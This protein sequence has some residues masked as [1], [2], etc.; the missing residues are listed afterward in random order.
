[1][2]KLIL[3]VLVTHTLL[4]TSNQDNQDRLLYTFWVHIITTYSV[5]QSSMRQSNC[6][7]MWLLHITS[8]LNWVWLAPL[9]YLIQF[10]P[11]FAYSTR[12]EG[13]GAQLCNVTGLPLASFW[14]LERG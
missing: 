12:W 2:R 14:R 13:L 4:C 6:E 1:M 9:A 8:H 3:V 7:Y 10:L 11:V 5:L